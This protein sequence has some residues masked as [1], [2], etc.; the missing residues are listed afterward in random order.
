MGRRALATAYDMDGAFNDVALTL[1]RGFR[2]EDVL[3]RLDALLDRYGGLGA[4]GR[5]DQL[6][7]RYLTE[8]FHQLRRSAT[9]FPAIFIGVA[10]F[11]LHV[12]VSR[13]VGT[14]REQIGILKAFGYRPAAIGWH[15]VKLVVVIV[16]LGV[17]G[18]LGVGAWLGRG[19]AEMYTGFFRF[20]FLHYRLDPSVA[21]AAT[22][23]CTGAALA[24]TLHAVWRAVRLPPAE[25]MRPESPLRYR[26]T[27]LDRLGI[28][29][30][31]SPPT[32]IIARNVGRRPVRTL[33]SVT[34][35]ALACAVMIAGRFSKDAI[36]F[37]VDV[38]FRHA[39][40]ED[41]TV[42]LT[43]PTS[44]RAMYEL[45]G[46]PGVERVEAFRSVP[47]RLSF[48]HRTYRTT[49]EAQESGSRLH[50]LLDTRLAP[51]TVPAAGIVL[52][53]Y[54]G[55]LLGVKPGDTLTVEILEG[56]RPVRRVAVAGLVRQYIGVMGY[57]DLAAL[58]RLLREG[59]AVSGV[60]LTVD[61]REQHRTYRTLV[62]MPRVAGA[63]VR[64]DEIRNFYETQAEFLLF[65]TFVATIL[66]GT[67]AVGVVYNNARI[68]LSERSRELASLRV[69]GYTRAEISY[70]LLGELCVLALA[71]IPPGFLLGHGLAAYIAAALQTDLFRVPVVIEPA[72]YALAAAVVLASTGLS[73]L[74][75]GRRLQRLDLIAALKARE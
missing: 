44:R 57:M 50:L 20:P 68:A 71:A 15:Y 45:A 2:P 52:T 35:I 6:S 5:A 37:M 38:Q 62:E 43:E 23:V 40:K 28:A 42:T 67:I 46:L 17:S 63:A 13:T 61:S 18:G 11:L 64:E 36:D 69:L 26:Q 49:I 75:V 3:G 34:G 22:V 21:A 55:N 32:L 59:H 66:A 51:M 24:G 16:L 74:L 33:L 19:L 31:L 72:T 48:E 60:R 53:D 25:A 8:E 30:W 39:S 73:G 65:F 58:N 29:G 47:V 10:A 70:I 14:Q 7:N 41:M 56:A 27:I 12:V 1:A 9:I 4:Y 54:L